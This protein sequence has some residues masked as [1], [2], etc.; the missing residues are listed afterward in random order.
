MANTDVTLAETAKSPISLPGIATHGYNSIYKITW[1]DVDEGS[2]STDT[3]TVTLANTPAEWI[4]DKAMVYVKTAFAGTA[5]GFAIE[6][7]TDGDPNNFITSSSVK[8]AG[9]I[10]TLAGSAPTTLVGS[11]GTASDVIECVFTNSTSGA[12]EDL[13]AGELYVLL[14]IIDVDALANV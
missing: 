4:I 13:T 1:E 10:I 11:F 12:P 14:N 7:G 8:T 6:V 5:G 9:P 2:G 3:V